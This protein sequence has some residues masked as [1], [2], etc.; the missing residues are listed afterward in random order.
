MNDELYEIRKRKI[1]QLKKQYFKGE[2]NMKKNLK[3]KPFEINDAD[4][5]E[6]I[7]KYSFIVIDCWASWCGPCRMMAPVIDDLAREMQGKIVFGKV[8]VDENPAIS[9]KYNIM[10]IPTLLVFKNGNLVDRIIGF[11][12]K[13]E[14][15][16]K[17][18]LY[19]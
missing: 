6:T 3:N 2:K 16:N 19:Q 5:D 1:E 17:L 15:K 13:E 10:S 12:P 4:F 7:K 9:V 18:M 14:L 8:N 11:Y